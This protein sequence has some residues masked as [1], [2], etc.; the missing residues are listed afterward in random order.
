MII[1]N[2]IGTRKIELSV[3]DSETYCYPSYCLKISLLTEE[4]KADFNR[5]I[6]IS[7][8]DLEH[9]IKRLSILDKTRVG[10]EKLESMSPDEFHLRFKNIDSLGHLSVEVRLKKSTLYNEYSD[11]I[12]IA[13]E[14]DPTSFPRII[15][16]LAGLPKIN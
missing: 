13:F 8:T 10:D 7:L 9:F 1:Q 15:S 6:W 4:L 11:T 16:D 5:S 14:I 2:E 12:Q 3:S